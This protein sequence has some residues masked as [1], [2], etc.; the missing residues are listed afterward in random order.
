MLGVLFYQNQKKME[1]L[2]TFKPTEANRRILEINAENSGMSENELIN[3]F[4]ANNPS[5]HRPIIDRHESTIKSKSEEIE[6][7]QKQIATLND[8][9]DSL[10]QRVAELKSKVNFL[11]QE[12]ANF[13]PDN[14]ELETALFE[15][16]RANAKIDTMSE[17]VE[18]YDMNLLDEC[19]NEV[20][21]STLRLS[22]DSD[23]EFEMNN[24][25]DLVRALLT[26]YSLHLE[27]CKTEIEEDEDKEDDDDDDGNE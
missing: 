18:I 27:G 10:Q 15:L 8:E 4:I 24:K 11:N 1:N 5:K 13:V 3:H 14:E 19:F 12:K 16:R 21:G 6:L 2:I 17:M 22:G 25:A 23:E 20:Y 9:K 7:Y 26:Q